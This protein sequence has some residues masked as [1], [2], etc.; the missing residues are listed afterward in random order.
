MST[1]R[2]RRGSSSNIIVSSLRTVSRSHSQM[3]DQ[4]RPIN[5][6]LTWVE[7]SFCCTDARVWRENS[8]KADTTRNDSIKEL[9]A[10]VKLRFEVSEVKN[11]LQAFLGWK[12]RKFVIEKM[13]RGWEVFFIV[14]FEGVGDWKGG[15]RGEFRV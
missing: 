3:L 11:S 9:L 10:D 1:Q 7:R 2:T 15:M 8:T 13:C 14:S 6:G 4:K 5:Q 12:K